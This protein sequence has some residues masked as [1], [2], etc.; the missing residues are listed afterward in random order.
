MRID[1]PERRNPDRFEV[2]ARLPPEELDH[3]FQR[4]RRR[5][6]RNLRGD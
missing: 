2:A 5:G 1:R 4:L 6:G 3:R